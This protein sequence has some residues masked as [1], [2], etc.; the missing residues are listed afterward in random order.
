MSHN[1]DKPSFGAK[2]LVREVAALCVSGRSVYKHKPGVVAFDRR[3][4]ARTFPGGVP[5]IAHPPCRLW[6]KFLWHQ[7][8]SPD[9]EAEKKL[10][11]WCV[12]QV[13]KN[14]GVLEH[15]AGSGLFAA[16]NLPVPNE[17]AETFLY[18]IYVEQGWFGY[19]SRKPTW[20]LISGVPK[21]QLPAL[22]FEFL[23]GVKASG[24]TAF[25]RAR[26]VGTFAD[27]LCQTARATWWSM[28]IRSMPKRSPGLG[29]NV[30]G[31]APCAISAAA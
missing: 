20:V 2:S 7:A 26:T 6:S 27:W 18:T 17:P 9:P 1:S 5:V 16:A 31:P 28:P 10:G 8:K 24:L 25:A 4:D 23:D 11:L 3:R 12:E 21:S 30:P 29:A 14:G 15:P 13:I 22:P 19:A